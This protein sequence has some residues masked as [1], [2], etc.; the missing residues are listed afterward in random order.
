LEADAGKRAA[1]GGAMLASILI[2]DDDDAIR[3]VLEGLL[4]REGYQIVGAENGREALKKLCDR[5]PDLALV[6]LL[7]PDISGLELSSAMRDHSPG[8]PILMLTGALFDANDRELLARVGV[9]DVLIKPFDR[10]EL[11]AKVESMLG[12]KAYSEEL[13]RAGAGQEKNVRVDGRSSR[14]NSP[15]QPRA[16][17]YLLHF[18]VRYRA[19]G[20]NNWWTGV[21]E[22]ISRSGLL[23]RAEHA[24]EP[25]HQVEMTFM[26]PV[27]SIGDPPAEVTCHAEIVRVVEPGDTQLPPAFGAKILNYRLQR[28]Q[29][30][31]AA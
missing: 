11:L 4:S 1:P 6:D 27:T 25:N 5:R 20:D 2:V 17:R 10:K 16:H 15:D 21:T 13:D 12:L 31:N 7:L 28:T 9:D 24:I 23:F 29:T 19:V 14:K 3:D 22:N 18:P 8:M 26:L 30:Q